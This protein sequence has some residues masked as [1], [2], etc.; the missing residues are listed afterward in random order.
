MTPKEYGEGCRVTESKVNL[1][2]CVDGL[3]KRELNSRLLHAAMGLSTEAGEILDVIKRHAFYGKELC[4]LDLVNLLEEAGDVSWY[5][6]GILLDELGKQLELADPINSCLVGNIAKL[7]A[8]YG[9][10]F[11]EFGALHRDVIAEIE[12]LKTSGKVAHDPPVDESKE[13]V[14]TSVCTCGHTNSRF[15]DYEIVR[16]DMCSTHYKTRT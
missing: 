1:C 10:R 11:N 3:P 4:Y 9:E 12:A 14:F 5:L 13:K 8:R 16:C 2:I 6:M 15:V 7:K